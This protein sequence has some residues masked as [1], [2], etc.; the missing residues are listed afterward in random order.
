VTLAR[1]VQEY[2]ER[3]SCQCGK[4]VDAPEQPTEPQGQRHTADMV[5]FRVA[6]KGNPNK[7]ELLS[8]VASHSGVFNTC[9]PY[10]G[11]EHNYMELGGWIGDQGLALQFMGLSALL[12]VTRLLTPVSLLHLTA[13][14]PLAKQL[15]GVGLVAIQ[16]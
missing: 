3:G 8:L 16:T 6:L 5:F 4:C 7:D 12:G 13:D 11:K 1:F 10:D 9:D 2:T 15:A 14:D